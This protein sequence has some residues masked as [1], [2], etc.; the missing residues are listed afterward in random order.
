MCL[1]VAVERC[2]DGSSSCNLCR[3]VIN[4]SSS[5]F[6]FG[7]MAI[8]NTGS[9]GGGAGTVTGVAFGA[10]V[11]PVARSASLA[12]AAMSPAGTSVTLSCSLPRSVKSAWSR[13]SLWVRG[14][15]S[16]VSGLIV[17]DRTL[18]IEILPT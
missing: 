14:L 16:M 5:P 7:W 9:S 12:T 18:N 2:S 13:S 4:L 6:D 10:S 15:V 3:A 1:L 17:P 8:D 11:S